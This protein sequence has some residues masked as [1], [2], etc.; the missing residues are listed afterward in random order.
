MSMTSGTPP[1]IETGASPAPVILPMGLARGSAGKASPDSRPRAR[2]P[3]T[4]LNSF[5]FPAVL[6]RSEEPS[7]NRADKSVC[8][9]SESPGA[10][11]P[12]CDSAAALQAGAALAKA[13]GQRMPASH[14]SVLAITSP[15]DGD[16]KSHLMTVLAPEFA[17]R[18]PQGVLAVDADFR[19]ADL[20]SLLAL[21][22]SRTPG[23]SPLIYPTDLPGLSV[24]PRPPGF[25]WRY[26]DATWVESIREAWSLTL[27]DLASLEHAETVSLLPHCDGVCLVVRLGHTSHRAV[28]EAGHVISASGC[29]LWGTVIVG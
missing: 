28:A 26:L 3:A 13:I 23:G 24:L 12:K 21:A 7:S 17:K 29:P 25:E 2:Q 22:A 9:R 5:A 18:M 6:P 19:K 16:G 10:I 20:T 14:S 4:P 27:L 15:G 1:T 8:S 11:W